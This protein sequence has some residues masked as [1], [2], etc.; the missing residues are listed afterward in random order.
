[1]AD[2]IIQLNEAQWNELFRYLG[3]VPKNIDRAAATAINRTVATGATRIRRD[4][5]RLIKMPVRKFGNRVKAMKT[6]RDELRGAIRIY[7][8]NI[9]LIKT[10]VVPVKGGSYPLEK[11]T[12]PVAL[13]NGPFK[14]TM[15][16]GHTGWFVR[17]GRKRLLDVTKMTDKSRLRYGAKLRQ[18]IKQVFAPAPRKLWEESPGVAAAALADINEVL[19]KNLQSQIDRFLK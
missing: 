13:A 12:E 11:K 16:S 3:S 4:L 2:I 10:G 19:E 1:M 14:A 9:P 18:P 17:Y 7:N 5:A 15:R 8:F 6:D